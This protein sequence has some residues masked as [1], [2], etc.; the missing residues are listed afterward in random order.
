MKVLGFISHLGKRKGFYLYRKDGI[1]AF[2][3][4]GCPSGQPISPIL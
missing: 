2:N 4:K 1:L 3:K